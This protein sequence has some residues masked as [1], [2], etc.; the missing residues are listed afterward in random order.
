MASTGTTEGEIAADHVRML[1]GVF[2]HWTNNSR[3]PTF[4]EI[5]KALDLDGLDA[6]AL[7]RCLQP[8]YL[9]C[10]QGQYPGSES[11]IR[12]TTEGL[13]LVPEASTVASHFVAAVRF[14]AEAER[15]HSPSRQVPEVRV[16]ANDLALYFGQSTGVPRPQ[17]V[18][19]A[20]ALRLEPF[21]RADG[22]L[23][24]GFNVNEGVWSLTVSRDIRKFRDVSTLEEYLQRLRD[25]RGTASFDM[26]IATS[27]VRESIMEV[28]QP[29]DRPEP[30]P[31]AVFVVHGRDLTARD[32]LADFLRAL[33]LSPIDF[34]HMV[35]AT[36]SGSPYIGDA[37]TAG[38]LA[39]QAVIVLLTPDDEARLHTKLHGPGEP[40][41]ETQ[42]TG[43]ARPN[44]L[45]EAGMAFAMHPTRTV[46]V[47]IGRLRPFSDVAGRHT[48][49]LGSVTSLHTLAQRL[50]RAGCSVNTSGSDWL[51]TD[52]FDALGAHHRAPS[53]EPD[54]SA[55]HRSTELPRGQVL[56]PPPR[57]EPAPNLEARIHRQGSSDYLLELVNRGGVALHSVAIE[58]PPDAAN[59][60]L[61]TRLLPQWPIAT[62]EPRDY[63]RFP[64]SVSMGGPVVVEA[65][66]V[67]TMS[68]G[69]PY[70]KK[71]TLSVY[72]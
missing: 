51:R 70:R 30:D 12:V 45:F 43:Q 61:M 44:V 7:L 40:T 14:L 50:E 18:A 15:A 32:A 9:G 28:E 37:V 66:L 57:S 58:M 63:R 20:M 72:G 33:G 53:P 16:T 59:W 21:L 41:H 25:W 35:G 22:W 27:H 26:G 10:D 42:L 56:S 36:G 6:M 23:W 38:F 8:R 4:A 62:L 11:E 71:I 3:W 39:A 2:L 68:D 67:A 19:A 48:V 1:T 31:R 24:T 46:I 5:D 17:N 69:N 13:A 34:E 55:E 65:D 60:H 64:V 49:H 47:E 54:Q 29:M 52:R